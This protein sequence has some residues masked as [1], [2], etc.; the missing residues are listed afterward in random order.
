[1]MTSFKTAGILYSA[2]SGGFQVLC[3]ELATVASGLVKEANGKI[4]A[5]PR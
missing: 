5:D 2:N 4:A 1:M 3:W